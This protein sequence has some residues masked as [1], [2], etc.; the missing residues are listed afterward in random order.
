MQLLA[1]TCAALVFGLTLTHVLQSP[2]SRGL[3]GAQW[4]TVQHTF[5]GG[6]AVIGGAA[7]VTGL[8]ATIVLAVYA[9]LHRRRSE[10]IAP[11]VAAVCFLGTLLS[12][13]FGNRP[14]NEQVAVWTADTLPP[15]WV[16]YRDICETAHGISAIFGGLAFFML[17]IALIWARRVPVE[18]TTGSP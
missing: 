9:W 15:D 14:V 6:F 10:A 13:F 3:D 5:Y 17:A 12:Y 7:E 1:L 8:G 11:A 16:A 2:G 4:L 18:T